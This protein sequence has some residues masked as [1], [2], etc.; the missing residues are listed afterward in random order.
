M[1][2]NLNGELSSTKSFL[3][4]FQRHAVV[5]G[6]V[7]HLKSHSSMMYRLYELLKVRSDP[8]TQDQ[9]DFASAKK[10]LTVPLL[11]HMLRS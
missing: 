6:L 1:K 3:F 10:N 11:V 4:I 7:G 8:P 5:P 2:F 9:L